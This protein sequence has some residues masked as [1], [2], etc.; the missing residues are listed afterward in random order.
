MASW[1]CLLALLATLLITEI[2]NGLPTN[3][4]N[5]VMENDTADYSDSSSVSYVPSGDSS[6]EWFD[7]RKI[8]SANT[9]FAVDLYRTI[10]TNSN[11]G[12][13]FFSP[14][15]IS[16][17]LAMVYLGARGNT[18][19]QIREVMRFDSMD[20]LQ[21][22]K[23][24]HD[25]H[26]VI[27]SSLPKSCTLRS[28]N[29]MFVTKGVSLNDEFVRGSKE[30]FNVSAESLDFVSGRR[31][32]RKIINTWVRQHTNGKIKNLVNRGD[33]DAFTVLVLVNAVYFKAEWEQQF[34][35]K[36]TRPRLF[37]ISDNISIEVPTMYQA[38]YFHYG[39]DSVS[40][41]DVIELPY[42]GKDLSMM[43]ALPRFIPESI[44]AL[45]N[46]ERQLTPETF[47][48]WALITQ[49]ERKLD[50]YLPKFSL[51]GQV[52][53]DSVLKNLGLVD[54]FDMRKADLS[55]IMQN[56]TKELFVSKANH[57]ASIDV[58]EQGSEATA[59]TAFIISGRSSRDSVHINRPFLFYI[60][61]N[62]TDTILFLGRVIRPSD[63]NRPSN[64][65]E[66]LT[67]YEPRGRDNLAA[68]ARRAPAAIEGRRGRSRVGRFYHHH[69]HNH[70]P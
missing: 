46:L 63:R 17:G 6:P 20:D 59:A 70:R 10:A 45:E 29:R 54:L 35:K 4:N 47:R 23:S 11:N 21:L 30:Y 5:N 27:V 69:D 44:S 16:H 38:G 49:T 43:I 9:R 32:A 8:S 61:H 64:N 7:I 28:A 1:F 51:T 19:E 66:V 48:R 56:Y 39:F 12:N 25:L 37:H 67:P 2:G 62:P 57:E 3:T 26:D 65:N 41:C 60:K 50:V 53:L 14:F 55:G 40:M 33:L 42:S 52:E 34:K 31:L 22:P 13:I 18:S 24:L 68:P 58:N 36:Y 15:S